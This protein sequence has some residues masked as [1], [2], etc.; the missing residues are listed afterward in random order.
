MPSWEETTALVA[1]VTGAAMPALRTLVVA[2]GAAVAVTGAVV[3]V[4][5]AVA[6]A[7]IGDG[8]PP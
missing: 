1:A 3:A 6:V 8:A 7:A 2:T 5:G 4:I